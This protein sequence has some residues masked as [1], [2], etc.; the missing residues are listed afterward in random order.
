[1]KFSHEL[2]GMSIKFGPGNCENM[3][4]SDK[5]KETA[6]ILSTSQARSRASPSKHSK[7]LINKS[8]VYVATCPFFLARVRN[9]TAMS[10]GCGENTLI[11]HGDNLPRESKV[12]NTIGLSPRITIGVLT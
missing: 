5:H 10:R 3:Q 8:V 2:P 9:C 11:R 12:V 6:V 1:M 4:T 7:A